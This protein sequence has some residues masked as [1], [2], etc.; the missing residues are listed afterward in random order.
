MA[1]HHDGFATVK[2][3]KNTRPTPGGGVGRVFDV[4]IPSGSGYLNLFQTRRT[5]MSEYLKMIIIMT[6]ESKNGRF[7]F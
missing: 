3:K 6:S 2:K 4:L 1:K 5:A 7:Q